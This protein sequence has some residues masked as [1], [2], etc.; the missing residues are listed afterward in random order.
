M[1]GNGM[2]PFSLK[3][4]YLSYI[5][6]SLANCGYVFQVLLIPFNTNENTLKPKKSKQ[7]PK[8]HN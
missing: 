5:A 7:Q 4:T 2:F 8:K 1:K 3:F 6:L